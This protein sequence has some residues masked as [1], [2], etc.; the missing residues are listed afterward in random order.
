M[1]PSIEIS[2]QFS[3]FSD[4]SQ[5]LNN[6]H[7]YISTSYSAMILSSFK[8]MKKLLRGPFQILDVI[9]E[10][11]KLAKI[12]TLTPIKT[13]KFLKNCNLME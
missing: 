11:S 2:V 7:I 10:F 9:Q 6:D 8:P 4:L 3:F 1:I 5:V 12:R 13:K